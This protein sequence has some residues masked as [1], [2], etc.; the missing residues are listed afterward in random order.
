M[1]CGGTCR[2]EGTLARSQK[3]GRLSQ[4]ARLF[5]GQGEAEASVKVEKFRTHLEMLKAVWDPYRGLRR[6]EVLGAQC[7]GERL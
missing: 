1:C 6:E 5:S 2:G 4:C 3:D 7:F